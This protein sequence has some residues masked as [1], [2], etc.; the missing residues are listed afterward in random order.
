AAEDPM[1]PVPEQADA[2]PEEQPPPE[3]KKR[4]RKHPGRTKIPPNIERKETIVR[5][6]DDERG[7]KACGLEMSLLR[8]LEHSTLHYEPAKLENHVEMREV[9]VCR[10]PGCK[11]DAATAERATPP[12][13]KTRAGASLLA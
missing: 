12:K 10:T 7:C 1:V 2:E 5:V 8:Y 6:P 9:L 13:V 4:R 3:E 11:C